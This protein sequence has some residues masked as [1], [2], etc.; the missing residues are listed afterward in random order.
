MVVVS[1]IYGGSWWKVP[2]VV[3]R[4]GDLVE[5]V[6]GRSLSKDGVGSALWTHHIHWVSSSLDSSSILVGVVVTPLGWTSIVVRIW[7][8]GP[9]LGVIVH[10]C[11]T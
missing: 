5:V 10:R 11:G 1:I 6:R 2:H 8:I 9:V 7:V 3:C 4:I